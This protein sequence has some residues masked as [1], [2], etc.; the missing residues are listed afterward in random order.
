[1]STCKRCGAEVI[2]AVLG[3]TGKKILV[4]PYSRPDGS[5]ALEFPIGGHPIATILSDGSSFYSRYSEHGKV[6]IAVTR[7]MEFS[8]EI[9]SE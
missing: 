7:N 1:M 4:D 8:F 2:V 9:N 3:S 5:M 6:C